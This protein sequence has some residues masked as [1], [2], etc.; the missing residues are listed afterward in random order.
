M[1]P[2]DWTGLTDAQRA[3]RAIAHYFRCREAKWLSVGGGDEADMQV[4]ELDEMFASYRASLEAAPVLDAE[5]GE[6]GW[7]PWEGGE[8]PVPPET[9]VDVEFRNGVRRERSSAWVWSSNLGPSD[10]DLWKHEGNPD[11][12]IIAYRLHKEPR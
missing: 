10:N 11:C 12:H 4:E 3:E 2:E 1:T 7:I 9:L 5:A 6:D 8:C